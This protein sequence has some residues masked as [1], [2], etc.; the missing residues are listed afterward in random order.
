MR[1][2][3]AVLLFAVSAVAQMPAGW[4]AAPRMQFGGAHDMVSADWN[5]DS[6][7]DLALCLKDRSLGILL[8]DGKGTFRTAAGSPY[9]IDCNLIAIGDINGDGKLD[10]ALSEHDNPDVMLLTGKGDGSFTRLPNVAGVSPGKAH[11]HG[12]RLDDLNRDGKLD[13][14]YINQDDNSVSAFHGDGKGR[15]AKA[16]G[17]PFRT[18]RAPYRHA[19]AKMNGD[20]RLDIV[21]PAV[22]DNSINV[23]LAA[24]AGFAAP[25]S[26]RVPQRPFFVIAEDLNRDRRV[27][28]LASHDDGDFLTILLNDSRSGFT[29][30][31]QIQLGGQAWRVAVGDVTG[32]GMPDVIAPTVNSGVGRIT[33]WNGNG[34]GQFTKGVEFPAERSTSWSGSLAQDFNGDRKTDIA[35]ITWEGAFV[36]YLKQ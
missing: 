16:P 26:H 33:V 7:A 9:P 8:G 6:H 35:A 14:T 19:V 1:S 10:L 36:L 25:K 20:Q 22:G 17:S 5:G 15:F 30:A 29:A 11:N 4:T 28:V 2:M 27:D 24:N 34:R 23:L 3:V 32:D 18:Q 31:P 13:L 21:V 12:L